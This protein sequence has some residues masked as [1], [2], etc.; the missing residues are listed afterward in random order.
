MQNL[1]RL[2]S[3]HKFPL[4]THTDLCRIS[5]S[6]EMSSSN[7]RRQGDITTITR[8]ETSTLQ[9]LDQLWFGLLR[10]S[11]KMLVKAASAYTMKT[12][13]GVELSATHY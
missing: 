10:L 7:H 4:F 6:A 9:K 12:Y 2:K 1:G 5:H 11:F 13:G 8:V 3:E